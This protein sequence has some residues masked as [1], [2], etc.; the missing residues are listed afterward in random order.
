V[1]LNGTNKTANVTITTT[2]LG[3]ANATGSIT[4][5]T[6]AGQLDLFKVTEDNE[7]TIEVKAD[8]TGVL[9]VSYIKTYLKGD[10]STPSYNFAWNDNVDAD[11]KI[12]GYLVDGLP[13]EG[14]ETYQNNIIK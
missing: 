5:V 13:S 1:W 6:N 3:A 4:I 7:I 2:T 14:T 9:D 10:A 8:V 12:S 11:D